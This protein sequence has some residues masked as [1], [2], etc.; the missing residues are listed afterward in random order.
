MEHLIQ[1]A[2]L[3]VDGLGNSVK[4]GRYDL[5][6]RHGEIIFPQLWEEIG[7]AVKAGHY[8]LKGKDGLIIPFRLWQD[9][10]EPGGSIT[11]HF[12]PLHPSTPA[13]IAASDSKPKEKPTRKQPLSPLARLG[14]AWLG[15]K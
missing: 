4:V 6:G 10:V 12:Q 15:R 9:I 3:R 14:W 11:M 7:N 1:A 8:D 13:H 5:T 2:F